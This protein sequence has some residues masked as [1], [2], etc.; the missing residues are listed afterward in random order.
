[1]LKR[2]WQQTKFEVINSLRNSEQQLVSLVF[3]IGVL[4]LGFAVSTS[5]SLVTIA[6]GVAILG[7]NLA[8]PAIGLAFDRRYGSIK[9]WAFT[10]LGVR[11]FLGGRLLSQLTLTILQSGLLL[12]VHKLMGGE[13]AA[14]LLVLPGFV[15]LVIGTS[16]LAISL[17]SVLRAEAV[18]ATANLTLVLFSASAIWLFEQSL[19]FLN[20]LSLW[21]AV[22]NG[23]V[24]GLLG[25]LVYAIVFQVTALRTFKWD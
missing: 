19:A 7:S 1:M 18:L 16:A 4:F 14:S 8:G 6:I 15:L 21:I 11:G 2:M 22:W 13:V 20:P 12:G 10:P 23:Q 3:P 25:L 5:V 9:A 24:F 17:A